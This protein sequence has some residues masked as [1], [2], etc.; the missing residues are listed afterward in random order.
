MIDFTKLPI[1]GQ[2]TSA[3]IRR[4]IVRS[5]RLSRDLGH[6]MKDCPP[7]RVK[8]WRADWR[9]GWRDRNKELKRKHT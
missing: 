2:D 5:G 4:E 7:Y 8:S 6:K 1:Y 3:H 9:Q